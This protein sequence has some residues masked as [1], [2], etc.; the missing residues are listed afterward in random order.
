MVYATIINPLFALNPLLTHAT[1]LKK[2][3]T[4]GLVKRIEH[5]TD[6]RAKQ[7]TLT[8]KGNDMVRKLVP[9]V[10]SIDEA[11]FSKTSIK[12]QKDLID[13]LGTLVTA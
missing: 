7:V 9:I 8:K 3:V 2:L 10:E 1:S 4:L 12:N 13:T 6:T 5:H 11:F